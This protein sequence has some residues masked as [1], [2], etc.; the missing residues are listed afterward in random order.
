VLTLNEQGESIETTTEVSV[1]FDTISISKNNTEPEPLNDTKDRNIEVVEENENDSIPPEFRQPVKVLGAESKGFNPNIS[2]NLFKENNEDELN[3]EDKELVLPVININNNDVTSKPESRSF[4]K[5]DNLTDLTFKPSN[6][7]VKNIHILDVYLPSVD[8]NVELLLP[9]VE[10]SPPILDRQS[11]FKNEFLDFASNN[12]I[13]KIKLKTAIYK[14]LEDDKN[15]PNIENHNGVKIYSK[16]KYVNFIEPYTN[17]VVKGMKTQNKIILPSLND[18][19]KFKGTDSKAYAINEGLHRANL[20][21]GWCGKLIS[22]SLDNEVYFWSVINTEPQL[23]V[24]KNIDDILDEKSF[25]VNML[26][27]FNIDDYEIIISCFD[28]K[29][30]GELPF[31]SPYILYALSGQNLKIE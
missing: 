1:D 4:G 11:P 16:P 12:K 2:K 25:D 3:W 20:R 8:I 5:G 21:E 28:K 31:Y 18:S 23:E 10:M 17:K 29:I 6:N 22:V 15:M 24:L 14:K 30:N 9:N 7:P 19:W 27:K 26:N 13:Q